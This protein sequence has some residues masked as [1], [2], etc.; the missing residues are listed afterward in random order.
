MKNEEYINVMKD[1]YIQKLVK[2]LPMLRASIGL[3]QRQLGKKV[4]V[5]RQTI[6]AI[7]NKKHSLSWSLYLSI[8]CVFLQY[9]E[10]KLLLDNLGVFFN[11]LI[12]KL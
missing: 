12:H 9:E 7:E 3:T 2:N 4:G 5:S 1:E 6:V 10:T 8:V 11:K